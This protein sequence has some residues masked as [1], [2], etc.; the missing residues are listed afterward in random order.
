MITLL[1]APEGV[2]KVNLQHPDVKI[3]TVSL[4]RALNK[5]GYILPGVGDAGDRLF[6]TIEHS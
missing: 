5:K 4:E 2:R 1:S 6:D 3:Y